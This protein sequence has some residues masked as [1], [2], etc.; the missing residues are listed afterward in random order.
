MQLTAAAENEFDRLME[1]WEAA[2]RATHAFLTES[3][4]RFYRELLIREGYLRQVELTVARDERCLI[5]GFL[6][7]APPT[8][9]PAKV[10]MLFVD[11]AFHRRGVGRA[12][13]A[14]AA[15]GHR[16]LEL[17]VNE[18][19]PGARRFYEQCGFTVVG[20]Q[21]LDNQGR[22]FPLLLLRLDGPS[23]LEAT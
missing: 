23:T 1:I 20:R 8:E 12:L 15:A 6:G 16:P 22:P 14:R 4:I 10:E 17:E 5:M 3:D 11:P 18:Q 7:L 13:L 2:V 19:N 9:Q 21:E